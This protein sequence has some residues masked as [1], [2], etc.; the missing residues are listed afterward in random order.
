MR[1]KLRI[2]SVVCG[3]VA[4][5]LL[6]L[7][8]A[9]AMTGSL[10]LAGIT[11]ALGILGVIAVV[12]IA[13]RILQRAAQS[14]D[15]SATRLAN[16]ERRARAVAE[17]E[18]GR[19]EEFRAFQ[20]SVRREI[21]GFSARILDALALG[22]ESALRSGRRPQDFLTDTQARDLFEHHLAQD[23]LL[24][25]GPLVTSFPVL[26]T[27]SLTSLRTLFRFYRSAGYWD[28]ARLVLERIVDKAPGANDRATLRRL[29]S[30]LAVFSD[31]LSVTAELPAGNARS[32]TGP[33]VHMVGK[34]LPETQSGFT[35]RTH[36]T[37]RAQARSGMPVM[38]VG[39]SGLSEGSGAYV[40]EGI[41]Y[42]RL[43]G[44]P[45]RD[46]STDDWLRHNIAELAK[47]VRD[48]RPSVLHAHSDFHNALVASAVGKAH[49][50]PTVY[51]SRGF[52]EESWLTRAASRHGWEGDTADLFTI[53]G[54]PEAYALR[55][56]AEET[57]RTLPDHNF[58][59]AEVMKDHMLE[60][61]AGRPAEERITVV[62]NAVDPEEFPVQER[63]PELA[64]RLGLPDDA[65]TVGYI[66]SMV[67]YESI[68]TLIDGFRLAASRSS[69][70]L[71]LLLVGTGA[72]LGALK[73]HAEGAGGENIVFT[74]AVPHEEVLR[75]YGLI[76]IFVVPRRSTP[77]SELVTPLK[78]FEAFATGRAV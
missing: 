70:P 41:E 30:D 67:E 10:L 32:A 58:T 47:V 43:P 22:T 40:H 55:R 24:G 60:S 14:R 35:L 17:A 23:R 65:V 19:S 13:D 77:V 37:A 71:Y 51:E 26:D 42:R 29:Q 31:P 15:R 62:P 76:D 66:S 48:V 57:A 34:L 28:H 75:Y 64:A 3:V 9:T 16:L 36:Y 6:A 12:V 1:L 69:V 53:F 45:R 61:D 46:M 2:A 52:W 25:T 56:R 50:I 63:D 27:L 54:A 68:E 33:I 59:L 5:A 72:H 49:G 8:I 39:Q 7:L 21:D 18:T 44:P 11:G 73:Q 20:E 4:L 78:P 74:G 38:V